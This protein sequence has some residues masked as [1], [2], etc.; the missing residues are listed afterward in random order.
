M[1][2]SLRQ[3]ISNAPRF[4]A[5]LGAITFGVVT[6]VSPAAEATP[7]PEAEVANDP[8]NITP[9]R[10]YASGGAVWFGANFSPDWCVVEQAELRWSLPIGST[11]MGA[12]LWPSSGAVTSHPCNWG[13]PASRNLYTRAHSVGHYDSAVR[14]FNSSYSTCLS[15]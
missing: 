1:L 4:L 8:C 3:T 10:P 13:T 2:Q 7:S 6:A 5:L 15:P 14:N 9:I 11:S 12:V